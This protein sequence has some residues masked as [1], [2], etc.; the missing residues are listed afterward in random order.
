[1]D[2]LLGLPFPGFQPDTWISPQICS[3]FPSFDF[4]FFTLL[5]E[6]EMLLQ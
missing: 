2:R 6:L 1:M 4:I 3:A 5:D